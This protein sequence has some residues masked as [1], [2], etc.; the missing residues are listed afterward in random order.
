MDVAINPTKKKQIKLPSR[1]LTMM[2]LKHPRELLVGLLLHPWPHPRSPLLLAYLTN[3]GLPIG[4]G[5]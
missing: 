3:L 2:D 4:K 5:R 1:I